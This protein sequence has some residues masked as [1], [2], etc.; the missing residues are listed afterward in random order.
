MPKVAQLSRAP[1]LYRVAAD[2]VRR[3]YRGSTFLFN[4]LARAGLFDC[5][6][7]FPLTPTLDIDA[8]LFTDNI[9]DEAAL[10]GYES[11]FIDTLAAEA[12]RL[13]RPLRFVDCGASFGLFSLRLASAVPDLERIVAFEPNPAMHGILTGNLQRLTFRAEA[14][15][16]AVSDWR[17]R[18]QLCS[19][20]QDPSPDAMYLAA[21]PDGDIPVTTLDDIPDL[22]GG[23]LLV[24]IDVEGQELPV[25]RGALGLLRRVERFTVA[26]EAHPQVVQRTGIDPLECARLLRQISPCT[27]RVA[28]FP[29]L[30]LDL[31]RP[32]FDQLPT[33]RICNV[34]CRSEAT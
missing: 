21:S 26:F 3:D 1:W 15:Q 30:Q 9:W 33:S 5:I 7:T 27:P 11:E 2:L 23:G 22:A 8:P 31:D 10:Q 13:P 12:A 4:R 16:S 17:G 24:K 18:G 34:L 25:L 28:E 19:P 32:F 29:D 14:L 20:P 6:A